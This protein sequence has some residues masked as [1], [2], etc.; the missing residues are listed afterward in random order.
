MLPIITASDKDDRKQYESALHNVNKSLKIIGE[1]AWLPIKLTTY[2]SRHS[3][4][5]IAKS[6]NIPVSVISDAL[7]HDSVATTQ[8]YLDSID[9]SVINRANRLIAKDL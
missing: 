5:T 6:K 4:A 1:M 2:V 7:G 8:I 9:M 3:W